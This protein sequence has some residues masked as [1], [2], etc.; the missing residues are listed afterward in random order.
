VTT[1][2]EVMDY[3]IATGRLVDKIVTAYRGYLVE[4]V[5]FKDG[6]RYT[7][8]IGPIG[9]PSLDIHIVNKLNKLFV[10]FWPMNHASPLLVLERDLRNSIEDVYRDISS[11]LSMLWSVKKVRRRRVRIPVGRS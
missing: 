10:E 11:I 6:L 1:E 4:K 8:R 7:I 2:T 9:K 5:S 3:K